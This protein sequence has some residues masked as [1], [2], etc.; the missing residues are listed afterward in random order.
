MRVRAVK[1]GRLW[2]STGDALII[3][4]G[5]ELELSSSGAGLVESGLFEFIGG[6]DQAG[7]P[8]LPAGQTELAITGPK[9]RALSKRGR[10]IWD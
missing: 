8:P 2:L 7:S 1:D 10:L 4:Q 3:R 9:E 6:P 5:D